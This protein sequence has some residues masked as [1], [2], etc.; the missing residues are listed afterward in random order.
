M[1]LAGILISTILLT[2]AS[3]Y[4]LPAQATELRIATQPAPHYAPIFVAKQKHWL[5]DDLA[6]DGVT[7][8]WSSFVAG[9]PENESFAAGQQ[10]VGFM[11]DTPAIIA[12]S[13]DRIRASSASPR[14]AEGSGC[15]VPKARPSNHQGICAA[16]GWP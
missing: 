1:K 4:G 6:K 13:A 2:I 5:E 12:R 15:V 8:K 3:T 10:D 14:W 11:G 16:N 9:P 7:V